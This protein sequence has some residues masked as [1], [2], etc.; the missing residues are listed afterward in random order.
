MACPLHPACL[1]LLDAS[2]KLIFSG[3]YTSLPALQLTLVKGVLLSCVVHWPHVPI[4]PDQFM[5]SFKAGRAANIF[6]KCP[7]SMEFSISLLVHFSTSP[8]HKPL[9]TSSSKYS[10]NR[11]KWNWSS[12]EFAGV[13]K[14]C[15]G[16]I[17]KQV[18]EV[19]ELNP[20]LNLLQIY[21]TT[22]NSL[23]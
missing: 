21:G 16:F 9:Q 13:S 14:S 6:S 12:L 17:A 2:S 19:I 5:R 15:T 18:I 10:L 3:S 23:F 11:N 20:M 8:M 4:F 1:K 7:N 22:F